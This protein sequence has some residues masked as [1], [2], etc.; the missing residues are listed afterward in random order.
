MACAF[1]GRPA[2][3]LLTVGVTGTNG[4]TTVTHLLSSIFEAHGWPTTVI[5]TLDGARTTPESP[6]L[7]RL[8]AEARDAGRHAVAMEVSS[9]ALAQARVDG[10]R[11]D[12]AVFTNLSH[13]HLDYHGTVDAYFAAKASL[14]TPERAAM[15]VVNE[16]DPRG[17]RL[18]ARAASPPW[19]TRWP[20]SATIDSRPTTRRSRGAHAGSSSPWRVRSTWPT[21]WPPPRRRRRSV[22]PRT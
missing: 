8:L 20:R 11:F 3:A 4:K 16:D 15:A 9:H 22:C 14:F 5:G 6:V 1:F 2:R 7:Q 13:D 12:A 19:A 17:R 21:R 10:I 18:L